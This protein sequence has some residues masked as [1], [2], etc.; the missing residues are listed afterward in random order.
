M[1]YLWRVGGD[2]NGLF[3]VFLLNRYNEYLLIK[4]WSGWFGFMLVYYLVKCLGLIIMLFFDKNDWLFKKFES[5]K[6]FFL[7]CV[8]LI[9]FI[10]LNIFISFWKIFFYIDNVNIILLFFIFIFVIYSDVLK[11]M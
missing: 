4:Y 3:V 11:L 1:W 5:L 8:N 6:S 10:F 7:D 2:M 9:N